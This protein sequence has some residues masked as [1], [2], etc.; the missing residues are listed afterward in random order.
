VNQARTDDGTTPL[1][2]ACDNVH[3]EVE[4]L[5]KCEE[6]VSTRHAQMMVPPPLFIACTKG[7]GADVGVRLH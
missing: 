5:L 6:I 1:Y 2:I 4:M 3:T 7:H